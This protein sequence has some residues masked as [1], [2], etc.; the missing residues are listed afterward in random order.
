[1][2]VVWGWLPDKSETSYK[3]FFALVDKKLKE[4]GLD[5]NVRSILCDFELNILKAIDEMV[6]CEV[7][8]C[9]FHHKKCYQTRVDRKGFKSRYENDEKF[10]EFIN[11]SSALAH[12]P[13]DDIEAGLQY[14]EETLILKSRKLRISKLIFEIHP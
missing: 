13:I 1:M 11:Q 12:L 6:D 14:I 4:L 10:Y 2:P 9:F 3:V 5:L 8:G 7:Y